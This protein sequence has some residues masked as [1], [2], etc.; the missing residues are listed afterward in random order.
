MQRNSDGLPGGPG[1]AGELL[2]EIPKNKGTRGSGRPDLGGHSP[3]P[4]KDE[5]TKVIRSRD[6]QD[7][8][9]RWQKLAAMFDRVSALVQAFIAGGSFYRRTLSQGEGPGGRIVRPP[10]DTA[11]KLS[12]LGI[13]KDESSPFEY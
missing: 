1:G 11:P 8:S 7:E 12:D 13:T 2:R 6:H 4:P 10:S 3:R 9:S 5:N